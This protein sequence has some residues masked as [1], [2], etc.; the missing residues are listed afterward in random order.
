MYILLCCHWGIFDVV[1][2]YCKRR[3]RV[4]SENRVNK[5]EMGIKMSID[6]F[7]TQITLSRLFYSCVSCH[8]HKECPNTS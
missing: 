7:T 3:I 1:L 5:N 2:I 6:S 8:T 4:R